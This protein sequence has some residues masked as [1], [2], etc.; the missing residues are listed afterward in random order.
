MSVGQ[1]DGNAATERMGDNVRPF[2]GKAVHHL[3]QG[4]G[5]ACQVPGNRREAALP[6]SGKVQGSY[7]K[8]AGE[9]FKNRVQ[10]FQRFAPF[11]QQKN[12]TA[13]SGGTASYLDEAISIKMFPGG[14]GIRQRRLAGC[15]SPGFD[16]LQERIDGIVPG[17]NFHLF[18]EAV[19]FHFLPFNHGRVL[20]IPPAGK[21]VPCRNTRA[22][23]KSK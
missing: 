17:A 12:G 6:V 23:W 16:L 5:K 2:H 9:I 4:L 1:F 3:Q 18:L 10:A 15:F 8:G 13:G 20:K 22:R 7:R 21:V 11:M 14:L 19:L